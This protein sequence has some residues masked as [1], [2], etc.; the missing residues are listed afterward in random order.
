VA[1][2]PQCSAAMAACQGIRSSALA[3]RRL[4]EELGLSG[5]GVSVVEVCEFTMSNHATL[6]YHVIAGG[7]AIQFWKAIDH[8]LPADIRRGVARSARPDL[9]LRCGRVP[10]VPHAPAPP[11]SPTLTR[12]RWG[13]PALVR[14]YIA[15]FH[16]ILA[17]ETRC[18]RAVASGARARG[19]MRPTP[20]SLWGGL[21]VPISRATEKQPQVHSRAPREQLAPNLLEVRECAQ[22]TQRRPHPVNRNRLPRLARYAHGKRSAD[23]QRRAQVKLMRWSDLKYRQ[24]SLLNAGPYEEALP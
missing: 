13:Q 6:A 3:A 9:S 4:T 22:H 24:F 10:P 5:R 15:C 17:T 18:V 19:S 14:G 16:N 8:V 2:H 23:R 20:R 1:T 12:Q 7:K 11:E 21:R